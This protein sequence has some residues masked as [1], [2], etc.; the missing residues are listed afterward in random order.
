M[1]FQ[2]SSPNG[3]RLRLIALNGVLV[4]VLKD[5]ARQNR[6]QSKGFVEKDNNLLP[7]KHLD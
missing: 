1:N 6:Q 7:T 2:M 5:R 3:E 4:A